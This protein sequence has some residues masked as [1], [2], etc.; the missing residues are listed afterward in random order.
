LVL[1]ADAGRVPHSQPIAHE[2]AVRWLQAGWLE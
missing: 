2:P 1:L